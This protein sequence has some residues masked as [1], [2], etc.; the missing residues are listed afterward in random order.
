MISLMEYNDLKD[1]YDENRILKEKQIPYVNIE[2]E[3]KFTIRRNKKLNEKLTEMDYLPNDYKTKAASVQ[4]RDQT[5]WNDE[6][7][8][9]AEV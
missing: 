4:I 5:N 6:I 2:S 7:T 9:D 3:M 8:I 1:V